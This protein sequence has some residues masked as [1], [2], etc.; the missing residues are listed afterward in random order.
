LNK[1]ATVFIL[2]LTNAANEQCRAHKRTTI[3]AQDV[4]TAVEEVG[5]AEF[6]DPLKDYLSCTSE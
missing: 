5:F 1:A 2:Y 6:I 3:S 4:L